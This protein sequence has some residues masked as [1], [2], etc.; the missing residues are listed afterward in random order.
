MA[1]EIGIVG[2]LEREIRALQGA[3]AAFPAARRLLIAEG[4]PSRGT[5]IPE[6]IEVLPMWRWLLDPSI[7][8]QG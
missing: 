4:P 1:G 5:R 6:G 8:A 2:T 7:T 3:S